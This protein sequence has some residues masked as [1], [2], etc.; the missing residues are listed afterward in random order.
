MQTIQNKLYLGGISAE[1]LIEDYG[2]PL[3][4]YEEE[5]ILDK[6]Q[7]LHDCIT[8][9]HK[10]ILY[11]IKTNPNLA[12]AKLLQSKKCGIDAVSPGE[13]LLALH[14]GFSAE[15]ILFTGNNMT[16]AEMDFAVKEKVL[17]NI[18]SLS[19]LEKFGKKYPNKS[20]CIRVN[21][22]IVTQV[23]Q[24]VIT[25]GP[26]TKFGINHDQIEEVKKIVD[27][28][29]LNLIGVHS[30]IGSGI[31]D[32]EK[33]LLAMEVTC[34]I[35]KKFD[36][37]EF[38]DFGGGIGIAYKPEEKNIDLAEFGQKV[39][40]YFE[41]FCQQYG[42]KLTLIIEPGRFLVG[43][44]G[45]LL[46]KVNT[47]KYNGARKFAGTDSGFNHLIRPTMY[48]SYHPTYNASNMQGEIEKV[49]ICGNICESGDL[50]ARDREIPKIK[51]D[52]IVA[53]SHSGAYGFAMASNYN[54]RP[55]PAEVI[56]QG[57]KAKL[58]RKRQSINDLLAS[59]GV[60]FD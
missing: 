58:A 13:I 15:D 29:N 38:V 59:Y 54:L 11:A 40:Q 34:E 25:A 50:F 44:S 20:V 12:I 10:R 7:T 16:D 21:P 57:G 56:V 48:G 14:A 36:S 28:Y 37:L 49:D 19:R 23:H 27:Q 47:I 42:K 5:T 60:R 2:S 53:I 52:D 30:H 26:K 32:P 39:S 41:K 22:N 46:T 51:E 45:Y 6:F 18:D 55:F 33:F 43:E 9:P 4:V 17:L 24:H 3:Y 8:Y 31:L 1:K 35:A